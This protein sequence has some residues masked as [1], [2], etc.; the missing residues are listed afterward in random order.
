MV[1]LQLTRRCLYFVQ[2]MPEGGVAFYNSGE[3]AGASQPHK[4]LQ[5]GLPVLFACRP[6]CYLSRMLTMAMSFHTCCLWKT[7]SAHCLQCYCK[8]GF[9][10]EIPIDQQSHHMHRLQDLNWDFQSCCGTSNRLMAHMAT[11]AAM[12]MQLL[13][14]CACHY[15]VRLIAEVIMS[16]GRFQGAFFE[17]Y[18]AP[19]RGS[20]QSFWLAWSKVQEKT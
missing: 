18:L 5:V 13:L 15:V 19:Q 2:A 16:K 7:E 6:A 11:H 20:S 12:P 8:W 14:D 4:H 3:V 1:R 17:Q 9:P 10:S